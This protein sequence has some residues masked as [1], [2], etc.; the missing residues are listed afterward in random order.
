MYDP[1]GFAAASKATRKL[2]SPSLLT[3]GVWVALTALGVWYKLSRADGFPGYFLF[4]M[5]LGFLPT[6]L[7]L[8]AIAVFVNWRAFAFSYGVLLLV[9]L[10]WEA[11]LGV[12][13]DW[14]NYKRE[15]MLGIE[16]LAWSA[17]PIEAVMLWLVIAWDCVIA[18]EIYKVFFHMDRGVK[19]ALLGTGRPA[20]PSAGRAGG[21]G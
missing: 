19:A 1:D 15:R 5:I 6:F 14:W 2:L 3:L 12:P 10:V 7:F 18:L 13:Y 11:T 16:V 21:P 9:S 17:L 8:R 4:I 20:S